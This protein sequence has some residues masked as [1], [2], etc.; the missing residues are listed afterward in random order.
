MDGNDVKDDD[1]HPYDDDYH[2]YYNDESYCFRYQI[3]RNC[4]QEEPDDRPSFEQLRHELKL[5][6]NQ[7]KV[8]YR[9]VVLSVEYLSYNVF[10]N[11]VL[12]ILIYSFV[13][14]RSHKDTK[15]YENVEDL[16]S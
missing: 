10:K 12:Y 9:N 2:C 13:I 15:L 11:L 3:M 8:I 1:A 5:M 6:A 7:H 16:M 14:F 4:W